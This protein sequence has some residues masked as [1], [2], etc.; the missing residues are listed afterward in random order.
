M[1]HRLPRLMAI[2]YF[3]LWPHAQPKIPCH[4]FPQHEIF[5][6]FT[7]GQA[8]IPNFN[9]HNNF[10]GLFAIVPTPC[11]PRSFCL[12]RHHGTISLTP[13][14]LCFGPPHSLMSSCVGS[15]PPYLKSSYLQNTKK[16]YSYTTSSLGQ[17]IKQHFNHG[18]KC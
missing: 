13:R 7:L 18:S 9:L 10:H 3:R 14:P 2:E 16:P 15:Q 1:N 11:N 12:Y 17:I 8:K 6:V 5:L 4:G